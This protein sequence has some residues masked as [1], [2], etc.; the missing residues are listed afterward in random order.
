MSENSIIIEILDKL[1]EF[2][3]RKGL[4][5]TSQRDEIVALIFSKDEHFTAD[6]LYDRLRKNNSKASRA[7]LYR[8]L[9]LLEEAG[10][11]HEVD[12]GGEQKTYD[13]NFVD[14]PSHNHLICIDCGKVEEFEDDKLEKQN[15][16]ITKKMGYLPV[17]QSVR[18]EACCDSLRKNGVCEN[19]LAARLASKKIHKK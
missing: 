18:I 16:V 4:R 19:L 11:L 13:P 5:R 10:L 6:E 12:L 9:G 2:I 14:S 17:K 8:T 1:N 15:D 3:K 7:T